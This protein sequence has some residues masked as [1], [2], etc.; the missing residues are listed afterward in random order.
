LLFAALR[1]YERLWAHEHLDHIAAFVFLRRTAI[2]GEWAMAR[3]G[4]QKIDRCETA[5]PWG[6]VRGM[7]H[8]AYYSFFSAPRCANFWWRQPFRLEWIALSSAALHGAAA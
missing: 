6:V 8:T 2:G 7:M 1:E 4:S 3:R 5:E